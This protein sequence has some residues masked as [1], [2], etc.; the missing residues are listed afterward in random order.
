MRL[1]LMPPG[2]LALHPGFLI[3]CGGRALAQRARSWEAG[4]R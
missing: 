1:V 4:A 3:P 2:L